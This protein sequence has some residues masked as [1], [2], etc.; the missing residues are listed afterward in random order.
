MREP[1]GSSFGLPDKGD[2]RNPF[3]PLTKLFADASAKPE[4]DLRRDE[5]L[6][7]D[8]QHGEEDR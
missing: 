4:P 6:N 5:S 8:P 7:P 3:S 2:T 1:P